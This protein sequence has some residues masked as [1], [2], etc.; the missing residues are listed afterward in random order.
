MVLPTDQN[1]PLLS[2]WNVV[3]NGRKWVSGEF[4]YPDSRWEYQKAEDTIDKKL[5]TTS[6]RPVTPRALSSMI[7]EIYDAK[8][9]SDESSR[10][11]GK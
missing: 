4:L 9:V 11:A 1:G 7:A 6:Y 3:V 2:T 10:A 5:M 8:L